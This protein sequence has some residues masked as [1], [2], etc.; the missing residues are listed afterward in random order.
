M[1]K[2]YFT[3]FEKN[4]VAGQ[5]TRRV[6]VIEINELLTLKKLLLRYEKS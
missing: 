6:V 5:P 3:F 2:L 4:T 1:D